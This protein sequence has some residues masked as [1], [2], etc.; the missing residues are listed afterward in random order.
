[1]L[2]AVGDAVD[3]V[4]LGLAKLDLHQGIK[5]K[6]FLI[7]VSMGGCAVLEFA[8]AFPDRVHG[9]AVISGYYNKR[10]VPRL[11]TQYTMPVCMYKSM[12]GRSG[13]YVQKLHT[14]GTHSRYSK[15]S[16]YSM[17]SAPSTYYPA[18]IRPNIFS[19]SQNIVGF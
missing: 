19:M 15:Y 4:C 13:R 12:F 2:T 16:K 10:Q 9:A 8:R 1:M 7:G 11:C 6:V 17:Y 5:R 14:V 3:A 18:P